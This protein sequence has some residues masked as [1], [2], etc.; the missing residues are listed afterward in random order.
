MSFAEKFGHFLLFLILTIITL[1][2][3]PIYF[4]V[5]TIR[6]QNLLLAE[7]RDSLKARPPSAPDR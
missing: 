2:I 6:E 1:F 3:Y 7:I 5:T 4:M